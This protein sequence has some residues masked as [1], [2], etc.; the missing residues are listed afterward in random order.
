MEKINSSE[1]DRN[2]SFSCL[3]KFFTCTCLEDETPS[4]T[5]VFS[6]SYLNFLLMQHLKNPMSIIF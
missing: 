1:V 4:N 3:E 2:F 5:I 6:F